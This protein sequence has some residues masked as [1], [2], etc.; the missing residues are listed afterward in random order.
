MTAFAQ[1]APTPRLSITIRL[2]T[3]VY[4]RISFSTLRGT[5][6]CTASSGSGLTSVV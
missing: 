5:C 3:L 1:R 4:A 2:V 6:A